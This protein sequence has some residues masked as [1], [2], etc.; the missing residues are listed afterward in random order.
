[1]AYSLEMGMRMEMAI[2]MERNFP[3]T[4]L[5]GEHFCALIDI[6]VAAM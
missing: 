4:Q 5:E 1:L 2:E 6:D 3:A